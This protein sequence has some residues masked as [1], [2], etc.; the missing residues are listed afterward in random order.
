MRTEIQEDISAIAD[1][2][3][4]EWGNMAEFN[5][6]ADSNLFPAA[7]MLPPFVE[8]TAKSTG[9][10]LAT[11]TVTILFIQKTN[12]SDDM[13]QTQ[14]NAVDQMR[15]YANTFIDKTVKRFGSVPKGNRE[16]GVHGTLIHSL[17]PSSKLDP[18]AFFNVF[19]TNASGVGLTITVSRYEAANECWI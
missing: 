11:Y 1:I 7:L 14:Y 17:D 12:L 4:F 13:D 3:T 10:Y 19:D 6:N 2:N 15:G 9:K 8:K 16:T 5:L 18:N